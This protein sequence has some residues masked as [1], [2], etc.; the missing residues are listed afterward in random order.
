MWSY[1]YTSVPNPIRVIQQQPNHLA[2]KQTFNYLPVLHRLHIH[3]S[4]FCSLALVLLLLAVAVAMAKAK[5]LL[6][7]LF[8]KQ[9][10]MKVGL[11][12]QARK[13]IL[14]LESQVQLSIYL[15]YSI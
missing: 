4:P 8:Q 5:A 6:L 14:S 12:H 13:Y 10:A 2:T 3:P 1:L 7:L 9:K 11:E 15:T